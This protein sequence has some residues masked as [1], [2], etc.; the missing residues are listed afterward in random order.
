[1]FGDMVD[2]YGA[3]FREEAVP[4]TET[5]AVRERERFV[6]DHASGQWSVKE[7]CER[8]GVSRPTG[9][10][11][12]ERY[13]AG[14]A[15]GLADHSRAPRSCPHRTSAAV[16]KLI[17]DEADRCGWGARKVLRRLEQRHRGLALPAVS[18]VFGILER[19]GRVKQ[20]RR[21]KHWKH[22]GAAPLRTTTANQVWTTDFKGQFRTRDGVYCYPL[23]IVDHFSRYLLR[24]Q[25]LP[26]VRTELAKPVFSRLFREVGLP[27]AIRSDNGSPFASTGIHGLCELNVWW[28]QLGIVHQ[29]ITPASPQENGAHERMHR[30]LKASTTRPPATNLSSQQRAF[31][32]FRQEYNEERPH[33]ALNDETPARRWRPSAREMPSRIS[34]PEYPSHFE[35]RR[36]SNAGCFRL[37]SR[38]VFLSQALNG[39]PIGLEEVDDG[40]WNI[41]Y[42]E[43]LLARIDQESCEITGAPSLK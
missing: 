24:C 14:G 29:R 35:V 34:L 16:V 23:T 40:I 10:K 43:T 13:E 4:W 21:R 12:L 15:S 30:T 42:Y 32:E 19:H 26:S 27:E 20:K 17:L 6:R 25:G 33:E 38:Q 36:V 18:T 3:V 2:T 28:M 7:L 37:H 41:V 5:S 11:W 8:Y 9:Y 1:M 39:E 31:N 22:P